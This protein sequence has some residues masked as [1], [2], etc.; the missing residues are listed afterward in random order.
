MT[1]SVC[2]VLAGIFPV[3]LLTL[4]VERRLIALKVRRLPWFRQAA[5]LTL[6]AAL[7]GLAL[8]VFGVDHGY[9]GW[10]AFVAWACAVLTLAGFALSLL[11]SLATAENEEDDEATA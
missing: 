11:F 5:L 7:I 8:V 3:V 9:S 4:V 1:G 10:L 2:Q 6:A